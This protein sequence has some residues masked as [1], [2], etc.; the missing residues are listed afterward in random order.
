MKS[1][2]LNVFNLS[3]DKNIK[4]DYLIGAGEKVIFGI[5]YIEYKELKNQ[6][7]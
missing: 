4:Y 7:K 1:E 5:N 2:N 3:T 6:C